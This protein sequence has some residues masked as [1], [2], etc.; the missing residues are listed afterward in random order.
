MQDLGLEE[1]GQDSDMVL[2]RVGWA[3]ML[4]EQGAEFTNEPFT[5]D[6]KILTL[7]DAAFAEQF[8]NAFAESVES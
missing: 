3:G 5:K 2:G 6:E 8:A 4:I 7:Q 1:E